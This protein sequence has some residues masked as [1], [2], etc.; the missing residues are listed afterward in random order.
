MKALL[1]TRISSIIPFWL[2]TTGALFPVVSEAQS[3]CITAP[4][5]LVAW[6]PAEGAASD[7]VGTNNGLEVSGVIYTNGMVGKGFYFNGSNSYILVSPSPLLQFTNQFT[8]ELWYRAERTNSLEGLVSTRNSESTGFNYDL[9]ITPGVYFRA[10]FDDPTV[11]GDSDVSG[12][13]FEISQ[14]VPAPPAGAFHHL[15]VSYQQVNSSAV[16]VKTYVDGQLGRDRFFAADLGLSVNS[17]APLLIGASTTYSGIAGEPFQGTIDEVSIYNRAL[18]AAEIQAIF[19]AATAGKCGTSPHIWIQPADQTVSAGQHAGFSVVAS[20]APVLAYQWTFNGTNIASATNSALDLANVQLMQAGSYAVRIT[21]SF[22]A[23]NSSN[24]TLTVLAAPPCAGPASNLISWWRAESNTLDQVSGNNGTLQGDAGF[25]PGWVG[26]QFDFDGVG[27]GV[28]IGNPPTLQIQDLTIEAWIRRK[29]AT[30]VTLDGSGS[31]E[32]FCYAAGGYGF[33]VTVGGQLFLTKT[34]INDVRPAVTI[35][36]TNL[37][38]VAVTKSGTTVIFYVDGVASPA[39]P[40]SSVFTFTTSAAIGARGDLVASFY[41][42]IDELSIYGRA[43]SAAE[44]QAIFNAGTAGKCVLAVPPS[45]IVSPTNRTVT[46]GANVTFN[47]LAAG[48]PSLRYQWQFNGT[49]IAGATTT[50]LTLANVQFN[51]A[52]NYAVVVTNAAGSATS[53]NALLTVNFPPATVRVVSTNATGGGSVI[54]PVTIV[55]NGNENVLGFSL[56]F[57]TAKL[58]LTGAALGPGAPGAVLMSNTSQTNFGRLGLGV[59]LPTGSTFAPGTQTVAFVSFLVTNVA[60]ATVANNTFGDLPTPRQLLDSGLNSL[61]ATYSNG[62][63]TISVAPAYE[64]D[65]FPRPNGD[66][67]VTLT[68]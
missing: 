62:T 33:G 35:T 43:L 40:F 55:A 17:T 45:I 13:V 58:T 54:V 41:G 12:P 44:I 19:N 22:G 8:I 25:A 7:I 66:R 39:P 4:A 56:N 36:D 34:G 57:E 32:F 26:E 59:I 23:T 37:H 2:F 50:S 47:V 38:H 28:L 63:V 1:K 46:V 11:S 61:S 60:I 18:S 15:A 30:L 48:S 5:G 9:S 64:G 53:S 21:N 31:G 29:S 52:G 65:A 6:W 49:N 16:E 27:D 14:L 3:N 67:T 10:I 51:Q 68:D 42:T 20:G 24:A